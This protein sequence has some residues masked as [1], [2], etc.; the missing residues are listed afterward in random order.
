M[1]TLASFDSERDIDLLK[2]WVHAPHVVRWWGDPEKSILEVNRAPVDGGE[3]MILA[4]GLAV[5]YLRWSIPSRDELDAAGLLGIPAGTMDIDILIGE[6]E[7]T[8]QGIGSQALC[9]LVERLFKNPGVSMAMLC[10]ST[11]N[12]RAIRAFEKAGFRRVQNFFDPV[13]GK[14]CLFVVGRFD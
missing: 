11:S 9:L 3:T 5:G 12:L 14:M 1:I 13:Y 4:D 2:E 7:N 10:T 8:G 6:E